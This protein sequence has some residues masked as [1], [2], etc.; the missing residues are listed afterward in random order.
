MYPTSLLEHKAEMAMTIFFFKSYLSQVNLFPFLY[1]FH[2]L[3]VHKTVCD[4][5]CWDSF[6]YSCQYFLYVYYAC[7]KYFLMYK[8]GYL[9]FPSIYSVLVYHEH[10]KANIG[11]WLVEIWLNILSCINWLN[12]LISNLSAFS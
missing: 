8:W 5:I 11:P 7:I 12:S 2:L 9:V 6:L 3:I 4:F 1:S 10:T